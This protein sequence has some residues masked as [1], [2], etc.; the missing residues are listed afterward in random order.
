MPILCASLTAVRASVV[1]RC[2]SHG[3][4]L[5]Y[6]RAF[7]AA[8]QQL[9]YTMT[10]MRPHL[11]T[12]AHGKTTGLGAC[13]AMHAPLRAIDENAEWSLPQTLYGAYPDMGASFFL[14][15]LD[16]E[17]GLFLALTGYR[18]MGGDLMRQ[19]VGTHYVPLVN[20]PQFEQDT[21][22]DLPVAP[23]P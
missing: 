1:R 16:G 17:L 5:E 18:L 3:A 8:C 2:S 7:F 20:L 9:V 15:R 21:S 23:A 12:M 11:I 19:G 22:A 14:S 13:L 4:D 10:T 6:N